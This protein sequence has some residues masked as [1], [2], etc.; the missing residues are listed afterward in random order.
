MKTGPGTDKQTIQNPALGKHLTHCFDL[1]CPHFWVK[2]RFAPIFM[3]HTWYFAVRV[4][5]CCDQDID[6]YFI[7]TLYEL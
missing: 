2:F 7:I 5:Q 6:W 1:E 4:C 3:P